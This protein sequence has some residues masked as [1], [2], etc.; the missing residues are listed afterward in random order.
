MPTQWIDYTVTA[1]GLTVFDVRKRQP[2]L[3]QPGRRVQ[4]AAVESLNLNGG[5][6]VRTSCTLPT[7]LDVTW[8]FQPSGKLRLSHP[9]PTMEQH[10]A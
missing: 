3:L 7:Q 9:D 2:F 4:V 5:R 1:E 10:C 8:D 6:L